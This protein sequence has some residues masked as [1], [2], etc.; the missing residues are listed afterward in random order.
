MVS[1]SRRPLLPIPLIMTLSQPHTPSVF[2]EHIVQVIQ[3]LVIPG[4]CLSFFLP[5]AYAYTYWHPASKQIVNR[6]SFRLL[7]YALIANLVFT[8]S[9]LAE[10]SITRTTPWCGLVQFLL[11]FSVMFSR[12]MFCCMALNLQLVLVHG[13]NGQ[14]IEKY[15]VMGMLILCAACNITPWAY[16]QTGWNDS[17]HMCWLNNPDPGAMLR[18]LIGTRVFWT[19]LMA[20]SE[21]ISFLMIVGYI[22]SYELATR[23]YRHESE[24]S[25]TFYPDDWKPPRS[26][27]GVY[28]NTILRIGLYPL[29][30]CLMN[31]SICIIDVH[32][33]T[34]VRG[35][36]S[37]FDW[38]LTILDLCIDSVRPFLCGLLAAT[39]PAFI[40]ARRAIRHPGDV[41]I[42]EDGMSFEPAPPT[43][44]VD[45]LQAVDNGY[46]GREE[47]RVKGSTD[48][49]RQ[50]Q[51][52][53]G[54]TREV[55]LVNRTKG[56]SVRH[57]WKESRVIDG[58]DI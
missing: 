58:R 19:L 52:V 55:N 50:T 2:D 33:A 28:R 17:T 9:F 45:E 26:P 46:L 48:S 44:T 29:T 42:V 18:W 20:V 40:R 30:S 13:L 47:A 49:Q 38:R 10:L 25:D 53:P 31:I 37:E 32:L 1:V 8:I 12:G 15:Y 36:L 6:V 34:K 43:T 7:V 14:K 4:A 57:S 51:T 54:A 56:A 39:D 11:D 22:L 23:R 21:I 35:P 3:G 5:C 16:G 41:Q 24:D 27:L